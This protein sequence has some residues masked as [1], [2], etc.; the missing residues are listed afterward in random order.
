[1]KLDNLSWIQ[2]KK[3]GSMPWPN[4]LDIFRE[5][6]TIMIAMSSNDLFMWEIGYYAVSR[7]RQDCTSSSQDGKALSL[8]PRLQDQDH[9]ELLMQMAIKYQILG[10]SSTC[11]NFIPDRRL[12][13]RRCQWFSIIKS[14]F[15][16][17]IDYFEVPD[18]M[19]LLQ[20]QTVL[21]TGVNHWYIE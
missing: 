18:F 10:I 7:M 3:R 4:R 16:V 5:S 21:S 11:A 17:Y 13:Q 12:Y 9:T 2:L 19:Q 20:G 8:F 1:M 14:C 6:D 15:S